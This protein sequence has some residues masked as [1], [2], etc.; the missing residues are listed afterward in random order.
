[1]PRIRASASFTEDEREGHKG[2]F[3]FIGGKPL[4]GER[5]PSTIDRPNYGKPK[6]IKSAIINPADLGAGTYAILRDPYTFAMKVRFE[7]SYRMDPVVRSAINRKCA[8]ILGKKMD[9]T[10]DIVDTF[11]NPA[12]A[13][14]AVNLI[15]SDQEYFN[16]KRTIDKIHRKVNFQQKL[17][18]AVI[19]AKVYGRSALLVETDD[20]SNLPTNI[21][22]LNSKLLGQVRI[23]EYTWDLQQIQYNT[24]SRGLNDPYNFLDAADIIYF[25]NL[26]YHVSPYTIHYGLSDIEPIQ[27]ISECNRIMNEED[28][29]ETNA[30]MWAGFGL[31]KVPSTRNPAEVNAFLNEFQAGKWTAIS[32]DILV[33]V[34]ELQ[35]DI[36]SL[37]EERN[38]N[39]KLI[40]R[41]LNVPA[42]ILGFED[43]QNYATLQEVLAAWKE[44]VLEEE[45]TWVNSILE[46]QW[47]DSLLMTILNID[48]IDKLKAKMTVEFEDIALEN[49]KDKVIAV[50]PL[51]EA[52]LIPANKVLEVLG[53]DDIIDQA[54]AMQ[55][56]QHKAQTD[57]QNK[58]NEQSSGRQ[59]VPV[60]YPSMSPLAVLKNVEKGQATPPP[61]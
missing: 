53:F 27:H 20:N 31:I 42:A 12:E 45:R 37:I 3:N 15:A 24:N 46:T 43:V 18:G 34:H 2:E 40:L 29:K 6:N 7:E 28:L 56:V 44:S 60:S 52:G 1:M 8:F 30:S 11:T 59:P 32:Q 57:L 17:K 47:F 14:T 55:Q 41:A 4:F 19:Q 5:F 21:K 39:E 23:D 10:F 38:E 48:N 50:L 51:Y 9:T 58:M 35:H 61:P 22:I 16:A 13:R 36:R 26:D 49:L 54:N 25:T 33:E